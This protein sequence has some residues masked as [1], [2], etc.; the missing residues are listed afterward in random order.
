MKEIKNLLIVNSP[1]ILLNALEAISYFKLKNILIVAIYN[2]SI[3]NEKQIETILEKLNVEEIIRVH[4]GNSSKFTKYIE[5]IKELQKNEYNNVFTG[6]IED[7]FRII[8]SNIKK[9]LKLTQTLFEP[10][11]D[12][13]FEEYQLFFYN[14]RCIINQHIF[15]RNRL[16]TRTHKYNRNS[17]LCFQLN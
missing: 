16:T 17:L 12:S 14:Q 9:E 7:N 5:L 2:R 3:N 1:L 15:S 13:I 10:V 6:E 11:L 4:F 8:I